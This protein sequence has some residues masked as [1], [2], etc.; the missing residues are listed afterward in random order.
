MPPLGDNEDGDRKR[1]PSSSFWA[2]RQCDSLRLPAIFT[3]WEDCSFHVDA[4]KSDGTVAQYKD[5][6][7]MGDAVI[8]MLPLIKEELPPAPQREATHTELPKMSSSGNDV[9]ARK[10]PTTDTLSR[11]LC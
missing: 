4:S 8:C 10:R 9:S 1:S 11:S 3:D 5:F 6:H 7:T 2:I